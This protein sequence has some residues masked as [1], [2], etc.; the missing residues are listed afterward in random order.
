MTAYG[1]GAAVA[2]WKAPVQEAATSALPSNTYSGGVLTATAN[3]ALTVDGVAVSL[4]DRVLVA[5]EATAANNGIYSVTATGSV[6][7]PWQLT[8]AT[9]MATGVQVPGAVTLAEEGT[10]NSGALFMVVSPGP[11]TLGSTAITWTQ[12]AAGA[13]GTAGGDLSGSYPNPTVAK[14]NGVALSGTAA[15]GN[16]LMATAAGAAKW[17]THP[18]DWINVVSEYGADPTGVA[19]ST[20]AFTNALAAATK[21][22]CVYAPAGTYLISSQ[23]TIP[24][25]V[26]L[27]GNQGYRA[28][29]ANFSRIRASAS[30]SGTSLITFATGTPCGAMR[31]IALDGAL[32]PGG[33]TVD[34]IDI[35]GAAKQGS[36]IGVDV[37]NFGGYGIQIGS[38]SG[39]PDGWYLEKL[40]VSGNGNW[41][42][43]WTYCVDGTM[44]GGHIDGNGTA[45]TS[46]GVWFQNG[47][48]CVF[49]GV[50]CQQ[51]TGAG[52][53]MGGS[54]GTAKPN[55]G[56][57]GCMTENNTQSGWSF[58]TTG[59]NSGDIHFLGCSARDDGT[60]GTSG[61]GYSGFAMS[62]AN[63]DLHFLG[64]STYVTSSSA[65]PDYGLSLTSCTGVVTV[66]G[67]SYI[68]SVNGYH[69]GGGN[70]SVNLLGAVTATGQ[71]G[72]SRT[73]L[74]VNWS[75]PALGAGPVNFKPSDPAGTT[76]ATLVMM[77]LGSTVTYTPS[78]SGTCMVFVSGEV[79]GTAAATGGFGGRYGTGTA[80]TNGAAVTGTRFGAA[81]DPS[82]A[83][84]VAASRPGGMALTDV[85]TLTPG[86]AYWFDLAL[87]AGSGTASIKNASFTII[88][89]ASGTPSFSLPLPVSSG[90]TGA[91]TA[92]AAY[93]ALSPMTTTGDIEYEQSAGVAARLAVGS[94][95][96]FLGVSGGVPAWSALPA[97]SVSQAGILQLDGTA[98]DI[99]A[100]PGTQAAGSVGKPADAAH[101][102]PNP[103]ALAP[104]GL[105][106]ATAAS[107]YAGA[108]TSGAPASGTFAKGDYVVDQTGV[109]WVC[110]T[111]GTPGT[112][113][114]VGGSGGITNGQAYAL[115]MRAWAL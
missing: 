13:S 68:G 67:G 106:G 6:S 90:G 35:L 58:T 16:V 42:L 4:F 100:S 33:N 107:R 65:G 30:F 50:K 55:T 12:F 70:T 76:S 38:S 115:A 53:G 2:T 91:S 39:N 27:I 44:I 108:T 105:T 78:S 21:G 89:I 54:A 93:N 113:T 47:N 59:S 80:P 109:I 5:G 101:V 32:L 99:A 26:W 46:G 72:T 96:Q 87:L 8:R 23:L 3:G 48:N 104:T 56:F 22:Q 86:T 17:V 69:N 74:A 77:G 84:G 34:G 31:D 88:E 18:V 83:A 60:S 97:G 43:Y 71:S 75:G 79:T 28:A 9:D 82:I 24:A 64:C 14:V 73:N 102:H 66:E 10:S 40:S 36:L 85:L 7:A 1:T 29:A 112:W 37:K 94:A 11:F 61:S 103:A 95:G 20:T 98:G 49:L 111:A 110:T 63:V 81:A 19:D 52:F 62:M 51:N 57:I 45:T 114:Q 41:G 92:A 25:G 15:L